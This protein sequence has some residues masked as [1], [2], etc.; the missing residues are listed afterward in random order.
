MLAFL[1]LSFLELVTVAVVAVLVFG[2]RLPE[3]AGQAAGVVQ[4]MRRSFEDL[5]RESGIDR[6]LRNVRRKLEDAVPRDLDRHARREDAPLPPGQA[7]AQASPD[8]ARPEPSTPQESAPPGPPAPPAADRG[9]ND[10]R[11]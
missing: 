7:P 11:P 6:E 3:V 1:N 10:Q 9:P 4:R 8:P 5:R 2:R